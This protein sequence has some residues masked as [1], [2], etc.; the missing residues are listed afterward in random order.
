MT[1]EWTAIQCK[2]Y[3]PEHHLSKKDID[4][5]F[6][7]L[8][9]APFTNGIIISTTDRWG[10]NAE[11]ALNDQSKPVQRIGLDV[12]AQSPIDWQ[13]EWVDDDFTVGV[14]KVT[15]HSPREHQQLAIDKVFTVEDLM[16]HRG[17]LA[18]GFTVPPPLGKAYNKLQSL[19][20]PDRWLAELGQLPLAHQPGD[21]VDVAFDVL[22]QVDRLA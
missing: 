20:D 11:E 16:T 5:Y 21:A 4:S 8:G 12:L 17:G 18:Y 19:Q 13:V 15:R 1:G 10:K 14:E 22:A 6:T 3:E 9:K 2:F 7:A